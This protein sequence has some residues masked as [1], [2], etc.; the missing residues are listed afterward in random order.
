MHS[1]YVITFD[2]AG[3]GSSDNDTFRDVIIFGVDNSSSS[4]ADHCKNNFLVLDEGSTFG[5][6]GIFDFKIF[7]FSKA[8][9]KF[10][11]SFTL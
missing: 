2:S 10:C 1:G 6:N 8:S 7:N 9:T 5:I 3:F 4:H 11:L